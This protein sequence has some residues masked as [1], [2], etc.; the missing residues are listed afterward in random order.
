MTP[1]RS[2]Q[3]ELASKT[4]KTARELAEDWLRKRA[5]TQAGAVPGIATVEWVELPD[6]H[7]LK[8]AAV[9]RAALAWV[10]HTDPK[11]IEDDLVMELEAQAYVRLE[12]VDAEAARSIRRLTTGPSRGELERRRA[13]FTSAAVRP[14]TSEQ[15]GGAA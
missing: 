2:Q 12:H 4:A 9:C 8:V 7:P 11:I 15:L 6:S 10:H 13:M 5:Q 3:P 14:W 1:H